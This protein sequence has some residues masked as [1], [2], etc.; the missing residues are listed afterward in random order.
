MFFV[1]WNLELNYLLIR[2]GCIFQFA[3][4]ILWPKEN[5]IQNFWFGQLQ[6]YC[7]QKVV[8]CLKFEIYFPTFLRI[9]PFSTISMNFY[10]VLFGIPS[11]GKSI[12]K[13]FAY[14]INVEIVAIV[15]VVFILH[16]QPSSMQINE[17]KTNITNK[18]NF[19]FY[20][21]IF[22]NSRL[23]F[24]HILHSKICF[25]GSKCSSQCQNT[26][27]GKTIIIQLFLF[28]LNGSTH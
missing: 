27:W 28:V 23:L 14:H 11:P 17:I 12:N 4:P 10:L 5:L 18:Y 16:N 15:I 3:S 9:L 20:K 24:R 22:F 21:Y 2:F 19:K 6:K 8:F 7:L 13:L 25:G 26:S 1:I